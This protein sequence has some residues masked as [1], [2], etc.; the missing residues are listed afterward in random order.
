MTISSKG[1]AP[2]TL[3]AALGSTLVDYSNSTVGISFNANE[4]G[5]SGDALGDV[6]Q[7]I[8]VLIGTAFADVLYGDAG[9]NTLPRWRR[10]RQPLRPCPP[11]RTT[12]MAV[13]GLTRW[14]AV[15]EAMMFFSSI[16]RE[17]QSP[18]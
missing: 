8:E 4:V 5:T 16:M 11:V 6:L 10:Q 17:M 12:S 13:S 1:R 3:K 2:T 9:D 14:P 15:F 18:S 7:N